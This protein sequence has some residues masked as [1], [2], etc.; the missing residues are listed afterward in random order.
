MRILLIDNHTDHLHNFRDLFL[1]H[2]V[3]IQRYRPGLDFHATGKDLVVLSG[4]GG[5]GF[6]LKDTTEHG[7]LWYEDEM[8][9]VLACDK[10][11]VGI[12]MGFEVICAAYGSSISQAGRLIK[13]FK[14]TRV[15]QAGKN[16]L[17][18]ENLKQFE[19]HRYGVQDVSTKHF[20][21]LA[22]SDN[23]LEMIKHT[24][25]KIIASQFHPEVTG[26]TLNLTHLLAK[27]T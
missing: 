7:R 14:S 24:S 6:E 27:A 13:G 16:H 21:V 9:F 23:G 20:D 2:Q 12:C 22:H 11:L 18:H 15:S 17:P 1:N 3:E 4:G 26:G 5:E 19:Y 25:R 10:P 8:S